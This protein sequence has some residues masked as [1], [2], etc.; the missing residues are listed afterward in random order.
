MNRKKNKTPDNK[1]LI[2]IDFFCGGGGMTNGLRQAGI[3]VIAGVDF[4]SEAKETYEYNNQG[5]KFIQADIRHL[6]SNFFERKFGITQNDDSLVLV[7]CSPCQFYSVI[8]TNK[9][10]SIKSKDLLKSFVRFVDYYKP[11]FVIVEN[12]PGILTN[13]ESV[14]PLFLKRLKELN[15]SQ[16]LLKIVDM[17]RFGV[18]QTRR[19]FSLIATRINSIKLAFPEEDNKRALLKDFIGIKNGF[20][21]I[22]AGFKDKSDFNHSTA[23]LSSISIKR[24]LKTKQNGGSRLDWA[25]YPELQLNCFIGKDDSFKDTY[26]RMCWEKPGPTITT[27]FFSISNGRFGHPDENRAISIREGATLQ[28]FPKSY[29]FKCNSLASAAKLIGN[30]VPCEYAKRLGEAIIKAY[31]G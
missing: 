25:K 21:P 26:G 16:V 13:K 29:V 4:D 15:Y 11:G 5:S 2:A 10:K 18:P 28:T 7:G 23:N 22:P 8:N 20:P 12:V 30:A 14:L 24:L 19:R 3:N 27:K 9:E 1:E 31:R 6:K 17:S